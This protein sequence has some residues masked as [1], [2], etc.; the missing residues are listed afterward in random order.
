MPGYFLNNGSYCLKCPTGCLSCSSTGLCSAC[1][2]SYILINSS[3]ILRMPFPCISTN[4]IGCYACAAQFQLDSSRNCILINICSASNNCST[5]PDTTY[6][7]NGACISCPNIAYCS[8]CDS[9]GI[10]CV[11]CNLGYYLNSG[12][13]TS[14]VNGCSNCQSDNYCN[15][16]ANGYFLILYNG[17]SSGLT[18]P[19]SALCASCLYSS[20]NCVKCF[21]G[22]TL[23]GSSCVNNVNIHVKLVLNPLMKSWD[24]SAS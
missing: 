24:A 15:Q 9:Y 20:Q 7:V 23:L 18:A 22:F 3:C 5:C 16:A 2:S 8:A 6:H 19:C 12:S 11:L 4:V 14:C 10:G 13:C 17:I 1:D 21:S